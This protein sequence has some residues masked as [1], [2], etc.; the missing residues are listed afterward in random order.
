[1][2]PASRKIIWGWLFLLAG[3]ACAVRWLVGHVRRGSREWLF[4]SNVISDDDLPPLVAV[5]QAE[6]ALIDTRV[7][8]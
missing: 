7:L 1:M 8:R 3:S 4:V 5:E 6:R 2:H